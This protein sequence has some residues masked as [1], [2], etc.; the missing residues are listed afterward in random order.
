MVEARGR[1]D[2]AEEALGA[3]AGAQLGVKDL[4]GDRAV[5]AKVVGEPDGGHAAAAELTLE[6]VA[7]GEGGPQGLGGGGHGG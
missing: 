2:L 6:G 3:E 4:E 5:V 7:V 1:A